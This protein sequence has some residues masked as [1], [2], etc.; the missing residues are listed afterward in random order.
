MLKVLITRPIL[1]AIETEKILKKFCIGSLCL[2]L[3]EIKKISHEPILFSD[4]DVFIFTSK[5]AVRN[6][7]IDVKQLNIN[8]LTFAVGNQTK[9]LLLIQG[10]KNVISTDG[11]LENLKEGIKKYL[12]NGMNILHPTSSK[13]NKELENF[14][15]K[16]KCK[17]FNL[18][19]YNTLRV[20]KKKSLFKRFM[21]SENGKIITLYSRL[22]ARAFIEEVKKLD[23]IKFCKDKMFF[24]I[25]E[26]VKKEL[27]SLGKL[28][29]EVAKKPDENEMIN[30]VV[31]KIRG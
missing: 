13:K 29:I 30:L 28:N 27:D 18:K 3:I 2:P 24:V 12:K 21:V 4:Y 10:F 19:C 14:F 11:D 22:T 7:K 8:N 25:S 6:F 26:N 1:D 15:F 23:L 16:Y 9:Q 20:N 31:K 5:N 17:Y